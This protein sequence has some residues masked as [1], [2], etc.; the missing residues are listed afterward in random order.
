[1]YAPKATFT[2]SGDYPFIP[3]GVICE[4]SL[5]QKDTQIVSKFDYN[6]SDEDI[7]P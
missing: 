7:I 3:K 4:V 1:M 5:V 2:F 6:I